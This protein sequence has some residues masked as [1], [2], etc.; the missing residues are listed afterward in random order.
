VRNRS[1]IAVIC[2]VLF[3]L[4]A[5]VQSRSKFGGHGI[6]HEGVMIGLIANGVFHLNIDDEKHMSVSVLL[7]FFL[8]FKSFWFHETA[9]VK[10]MVNEANDRFATP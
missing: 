1:W 8:P 6:Y 3:P 7:R 10:L 2:V 4:V 9:C 5:T